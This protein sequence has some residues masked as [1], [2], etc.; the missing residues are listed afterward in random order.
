MLCCPLN[1]LSLVHTSLSKCC[2]PRCYEITFNETVFRF[3][4]TF[5]YPFSE[6][7]VKQIPSTGPAVKKLLRVFFKDMKTFAHE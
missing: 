6:E 4:K 5:F 3:L 7:G 1:F 2:L